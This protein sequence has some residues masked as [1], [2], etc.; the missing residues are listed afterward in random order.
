[1]EFYFKTYRLLREADVVWAHEEYTFLFPLLSEKNQYIW[2]LHEIPK[3]F[4]ASYM[5]RI[6]HIIENKSKKILHANE[7]RMDYLHSIGLIRDIQ[8]HDFIN[9]YPDKLFLSSKSEDKNL[10]KFKEWIKD[11]DYIYLQ[12]LSFS[13]RNPLVTLQAIIECGIKTV[14]VGNVDKTAL[15]SFKKKY[16]ENKIN[17]MIFFTGQINQ[18]DITQYIKN[19]KFSIITYDSSSINQIYCEPNRLYQALSMGKPVIVSKNPTMKNLI[20]NNCYGIVLNDYGE[21]KLTLLDAIDTMENNY[22]KFFN[23]INIHKGNFIWKDKL[24]NEKV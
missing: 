8:K 18:L 7:A 4:Q 12:G 2:D 24:V 14:V 23:K 20:Q 9:N 22:S 16:S 13:Q 17:S 11:E 5:K 15:K 3:F 21:N 19:C 6:F 10:K 1:M